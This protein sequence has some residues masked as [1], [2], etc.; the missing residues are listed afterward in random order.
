MEAIRSSFPRT[1]AAAPAPAAYS[2]GSPSG[3]CA[4]SEP[5]ASP[6]SISPLL[7]WALTKSTLCIPALHA[8]SMSETKV[9]LPTPMKEATCLEV[10]PTAYGF[11]SDPETTLPIFWGAIPAIFTAFSAASVAIVI[12]S[13]EKSATDLL[14]NRRPFLTLSRNSL[15]SFRLPSRALTIYSV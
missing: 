13:S 14:L 3:A 4:I 2:R 11:D 7:T 9:S 10:E 6:Y 5:I 12:V 1:Y 8:P 15:M